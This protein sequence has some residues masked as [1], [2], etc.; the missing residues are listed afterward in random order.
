MS[1]VA[2]KQDDHLFQLALRAAFRHALGA[3]EQRRVPQI[4][5]EPRRQFLDGRHDV[6]QSRV[7]GAARHAVELRRARLLHQHHARV[8]LDG[9]QPQR[10]VRAH[11]RKNHPHAALALILGQRAQEEINRQPQAAWRARLEQMQHAVEDGHVLVRRNDIH[12]VRPDLRAILHLDDLHRRAALEQLG[13]DALARRIEVLDDDE[14]Q[15]ARR[16]HL[17]QEGFECLQ[18]ARRRAE[19]NDGEGRRDGRSG[20]G[21]ERRGLD[22]SCPLFVPGLGRDCFLHGSNFQQLERGAGT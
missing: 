11:A 8:F 4:F 12:A 13:H 9:F 16:R 3:G 5:E 20:K 22:W 6:R 21:R 7:D 17:L 1:R 2:A 14:G 10:A 15:S 19:A 18:S